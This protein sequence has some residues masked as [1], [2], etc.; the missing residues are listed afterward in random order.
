VQQLPSTA[1]HNPSQMG[2]VAQG[3]QVG[4]ALQIPVQGTGLVLGGTCR[5]ATD[6]ITRCSHSQFLHQPQADI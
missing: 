3:R 4:Q 6:L 1:L 5:L 2:Q